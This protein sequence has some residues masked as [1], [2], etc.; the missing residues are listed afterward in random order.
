M[1]SRHLVLFC[2]LFGL[3]SFSFV[4]EEGNNASPD[5]GQKIYSRNP[6]ANT[7]YIQ[8]LEYLSKGKPWAGGSLLNA[9][10]ALKLFRQATQKDPQFA[11]AYVSQAETLDIFNFSVPGSVTAEK[12][13]R[14]EEAAAC[15]AV[16]LDNTSVQAH[17][18]LALIYQAYEY[19]WVR[20][21][22]ELKRVIELTPDSTGAHIR[23]A[24]F[25]GILGRF[26]E[27]DAQIQLVLALD[28]NSAATNRALLQLLFWQ[29]K[30]D[31]ALSQGLQALQKENNLP[32]HFFLGLVYV[33]KGQFEKGIEELKMATKLGDAG[34]LA[35][36][37]YAYAMAGDKTQLKNTLQQFKHHPARNH[38]PY[39]LA[40]V[41]VA[42]G[43]NN[44]AI[45][46]IEKDYH[47]RS[48]WLD[49]LKVD[50]AL[51]PLRQEPRFKQLMRR[52]NFE[53]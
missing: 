47:Q 36:L 26:E 44:K 39:R 33:H 38:V 1:K 5:A 46:L 37:A 23:Y 11:L 43:D 42:L 10:K 35:A 15:K 20:A 13:Y 31:A 34:S 28:K 4:A 48:N 17:S 7:L 9:R 3:N 40:A 2:L 45:S 41:Y 22:K 49:W 29:R 8:G 6:E 21:E 30:D 53:E 32:T 24:L 19:D 50:P 52:L 51:D 18:M 14:Q 27:A 25:L 12:I 16:E